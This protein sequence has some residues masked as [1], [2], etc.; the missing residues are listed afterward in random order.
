[1]TAEPSTPAT[2]SVADAYPP[3]EIAA[4]V[5]KLGLAKVTTP[6]SSMIALAVLAGAFISLGALFYTVTMTSGKNGPALPFGL[7]RVAGGMTFSLGLVLVVVG[8]A[9]LFTGNN[10]IAMAWAVG[11]VQTRQVVRN[12][13]W[14]YLGNLLG[15]G[16]TAV[17]VLLAG[18]HLLGDGAVGETLVQIARSKIALDPLSALVRGILCNVLVCLAVWLCMGAR[19][20]TDKVLAIVFPITAFVACGFEHSVANMFFLP[21]GI[22]LAAG[23]QDSLSIAG[24][25]S[26]LLLVTVGNI[27]GGTLLVALVYWFVYLRTD[28]E[29]GS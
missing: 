17:L 22:A 18:V 4:R 10:L 8:G 24:A 7:L 16:G 11:C 28:P 5:C 13:I 21:V 26:N 19:S 25:I 20:V 27:I 6:V 9:E 3:P 2:V 29:S 15:A 14:V 23:G 1:M 12:W